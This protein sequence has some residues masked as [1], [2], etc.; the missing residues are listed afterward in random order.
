MLAFFHIFSVAQMILHDFFA[1]R[2]LAQSS[3]HSFFFDEMSYEINNLQ[4]FDF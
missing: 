1:I 2:F 4:C 3:P